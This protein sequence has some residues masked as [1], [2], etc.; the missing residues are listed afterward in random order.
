MH[1]FQGTVAVVTGAA[2]GIGRAL[3]QRAAAEGMAVV[4]ADKNAAALSTASAELASTGAEVLAV[5]TDVSRADE[6]EALAQAAFSAFGTTHLLC[7]NAGV[8]IAAPILESSL[9]DW[10]WALGVNLWGVIHGVHSF[11]PAMRA[12][13][14]PCH[15]VNTAS[16]AGLISPPGLGVYRTTKHAV[17]AF[18]EALYHE[19]REVAPHIHVSVLCPGLVRTGILSS[20][21]RPGAGTSPAHAA[22]N[23]E[24]ERLRAALD[25]GMDPEAV[26]DVVFR[27]IREERFYILTHPARNHQIRT[28]MEDILLQRNPTGTTAS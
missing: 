9:E 8:G 21:R 16:I 23:P 2:N 12:Q 7:N 10:E 20:A 15:I 28:R 18:S 25:E 19:L 5:P 14:E 1:D 3:A 11:V 22:P 26:A 13:S 24:E 27:A 6:V 4:L 17:V